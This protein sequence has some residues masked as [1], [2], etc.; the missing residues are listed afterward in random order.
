VGLAERLGIGWR[1]LPH[2]MT[3]RDQ[4]AGYSSAS[5]YQLRCRSGTAVH[6]R[7]GL[8]SG[9]EQASLAKRSFPAH[10]SQ[11]NA[12]VLACIDANGAD[13]Y[14]ACRPGHCSCSS[15]P[16]KPHPTLR[17]DGGGSTA[18]PSH[19]RT[20][21][22]RFPLPVVLGPYRETARLEGLSAGGVDDRE[23][24]RDHNG[25]RSLMTKKGRDDL[26]CS[27]Q[28]VSAKQRASANAA[29]VV[30]REHRTH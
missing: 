19:S 29:A 14:S 7:A 6:S 12:S 22:A 5:P 10:L 21:C 13:G 16:S 20:S 17:A 3:E 18:G 24:C 26:G 2:V 25:Q 9:R 23:S 15:C 28:Q 27:R 30:A 8:Q 11:S 1:H 4:L